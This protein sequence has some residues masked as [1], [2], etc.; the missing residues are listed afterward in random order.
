MKFLVPSDRGET[1]ETVSPVAVI[2]IGSTSSTLLMA[3][4]LARPM[5][6][7]QA[8]MD[9]FSSPG[10][11][12][13]LGVLEEWVTETHRMGARLVAA[14]GEAV[15]RNR[16][17]EDAIKCRVSGWWPL[18]GSQEGRLAWLAVKAERP[19]TS[20]V[21]D[22]GGG[23]TEVIDAL[24]SCSVPSGAARPKASIEWPRFSGGERPVFVGGTAVALARWAQRDPLS[25][26]DVRAMQQ[27]VRDADP[28]LDP[29]G[30][31]RR[32]VLPGGLAILE[33]ICTANGCH[34]FS[35][36]ERGLTEGLWL[37]ASLGRAGAP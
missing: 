36:S 24:R 12:A 35:V 10:S 14:G 7:R 15:R 6:R 19:D 21:V 5:L 32:R 28:R 3:E 17:L 1:R 26:D 16:A 31:V 13:L 27:A 37:A 4:D 34:Q 22:V 2:K 23:S 8:L 25:L 18:S 33:A 9:L 30:A 11:Q 29:L 20:V